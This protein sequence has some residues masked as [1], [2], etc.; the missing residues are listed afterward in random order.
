MPDYSKN[1][2]YL[3]KEQYQELITNETLTV[4]G[5]TVTY[6]DNDIYVTPQAEPVTDVRVD[7]TSISSN[8]IANI[9]KASSSVLGLVK[10]GNYGVN[11][12]SAGNLGISYASPTIIK[13]GGSTFASITTT[14]QHESTFYG[15]AKA[16]GADRKDIANTTVGTYPDAQKA[17]IQKMLGI[18]DLLATEENNLSASKAYSI[19][20]IFTDNGKLYKAT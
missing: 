6:N 15:L 1:I 11:M 16:A 4:N 19:G 2:V 10:V 12:D 9:P 8:G 7:G 18:S 5:Q 17:A 13:G 14:Y 20:D 3:S